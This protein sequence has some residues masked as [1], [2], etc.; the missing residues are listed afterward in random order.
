MTLVGIESLLCLREAC[1][2]KGLTGSD[3]EA[4]FLKNALHILAPH[5]A[6]A[7]GVR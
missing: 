5:L 3:V 2:D 1:E 7:R 4:I 6:Y